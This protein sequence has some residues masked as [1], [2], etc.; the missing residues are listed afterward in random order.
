MGILS[1]FRRKPIKRYYVLWRCNHCAAEQRGAVAHGARAPHEAYGVVCLACGCVGEMWCEAWPRW[2][3]SW[4]TNIYGSW[5]L[6][7]HPAGAYDASKDPCAKV[8]EK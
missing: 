2:S 8:V 1:I 5:R 4:D 7:R 3:P 6:G